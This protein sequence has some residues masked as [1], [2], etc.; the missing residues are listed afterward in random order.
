MLKELDTYRVEVEELGL[1]G[2][3]LQ[4]TA[5]SLNTPLTPTLVVL[6]RTLAH[7]HTHT[8]HLPCSVPA[9]HL[10]PEFQL[11]FPATTQGSEAAPRLIIEL[12]AFARG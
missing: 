5:K 9:F 4:Q 2:S 3:I 6:R 12:N 10:P 11:L 7:T 8:S 1:F